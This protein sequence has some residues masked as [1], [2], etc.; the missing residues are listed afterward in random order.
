MTLPAGQG[1]RSLR[2]RGLGRV[3][4]G[5]VQK[6]TGRIVSGRAGPGRVG[7][8]RVGSGRVGSGRV[9]PGRVGS[10]HPEPTRAARSDPPHEK[11]CR[12][13]ILIA[14]HIMENKENSQTEN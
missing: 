13:L 11:P 10:G 8:G 6:V 2:A 12:V 7:S 1:R 9:G 4:S 3:G 5:G 14:F